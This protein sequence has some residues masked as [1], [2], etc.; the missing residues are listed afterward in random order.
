MVERIKELEQQVQNSRQQNEEDK[1]TFDEK[2]RS[3]SLQTQADVEAEYEML[4]KTKKDQI[5]LSTSMSTVQ[6]CLKL[7]ELVAT[8][9][10]LISI[11]KIKKTRARTET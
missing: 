11:A 5:S 7:M 2:M 1:M 10:A 9:F 4:M 6:G 8:Q 3:G